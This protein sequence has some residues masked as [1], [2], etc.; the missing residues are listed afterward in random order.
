MP[1]ATFTI[2]NTYGLH[3]RPCAAI[4]KLAG[5]YP[6]NITLVKGNI[7]VNAK[8]IMELLTL[9]AAYGDSI[10]VIATGPDSEAALH[11]FGELIAHRFGVE[12]EV[13]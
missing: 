3:I 5:D 7:R 6:C 9:G 1:E 8:R 13:E 10:K 2:L 11:A 4:A 12:E